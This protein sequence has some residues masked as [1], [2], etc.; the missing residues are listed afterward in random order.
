M[1]YSI[2]QAAA[3]SGI[4]HKMI[5]HYEQIGLLPQVAR[6]SAGYRRYNDNDIRQ[7][8]FIR[9]ARDL[10]FSIAEIARLV[11]LWQDQSRPSAHVKALALEHVAQLDEKI[12]QLQEMKA[13]LE[14]LAASCHG[15]DRPEC[16]ILDSLAGDAAPSASISAS[17][18]HGQ[19]RRR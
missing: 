9:R 8:Q 11:D 14:R 12:G 2:G 5:R 1:S 10:G 7:L 16:P 18:N 6:T 19:A 3:A 15:D 4:S 17:R 13:T